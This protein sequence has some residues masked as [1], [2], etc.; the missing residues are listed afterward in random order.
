MEQLR[1]PVALHVPVTRYLLAH[2]M[3]CAVRRCGLNRE[4]PGC[5][6]L[7]LHWSDI[8][9]VLPEAML[10]LCYGYVTGML[11]LL[12]QLLHQPRENKCVCGSS[13]S[14]SLLPASQV[15]S[16]LA[17]VQ[18]TLWTVQTARQLAS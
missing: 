18:R 13:G 10:W 11:W 1:S 2:G 8:A 3:P 12:P 15:E 6:A 5:S 4:S 16:C 14:S 9:I 17:W 7:G